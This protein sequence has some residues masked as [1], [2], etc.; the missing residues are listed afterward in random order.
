MK[1]R[2]IAYHLPQFHQI[3]E[4][5]LW[6]GEGYTEWTAIQKWV[7]YFK[8]HLL[9]KPE[10]LGYYDLRTPEVLEEQYKIASSH[11][12]EGFCFWS[13][14]FGEGERLLEKPLENLLVP[15][16]QVKYCF[17]WANHSWID[18]SNGR[19]LKQQNYLGEE[20]YK[21]FFQVMLPHF[22][23]P[24]YIKKDNKLVFCIFMPQ[25]IPDFD[26]F[27]AVWNK[28]IQKEGYD[29]FYFIGDRISSKLKYKSLFDAFMQSST[30]FANR[31]IFHKILDRL[32]RSYSWTFLGPMKYSYKK[33][34][35]NLY[36]DLYKSDNFI[37]TIFSG[38][39]STPR[40]AK[41]GVVLY[42]FNLDSFR[43]HVK[44]IFALH[45]KNEF[46]FIKSWNEWAEGNILEPDDIFKDSLLKVIK[47]INE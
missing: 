3:K 8:G 43:K 40:H 36:T 29:G 39:D 37:P 4:N 31:N 21:K 47:T 11:G 38:W 23:N 1:K 46:I 28:L 5:D 27:Y 41:R 44:D 35:K 2:L 7:P 25:D 34:M 20:D 30:M 15:T 18:K 13:Y 10:R 45:T 32:I 16:S 33:M 19:L 26:V 24:N 22:R 12:I 17:A 9:R 6:W 42:D 14:W